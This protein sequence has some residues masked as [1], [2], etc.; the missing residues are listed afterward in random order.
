MSDMNYVGA[1][2]NNV[3]PSINYVGPS[4][5]YVGLDNINY[6]VC[7]VLSFPHTHFSSKKQKKLL[8]N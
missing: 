8:R 7:F 1:N 4:I 5:N 3:G 6:V 2:I